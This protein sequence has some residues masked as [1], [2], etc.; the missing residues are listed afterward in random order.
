MITDSIRATLDPASHACAH[1]GALSPQVLSTDS[2]RATL[3]RSC[4]NAQH[5]ALLETST[6]T[7]GD[8][9]HS[10]TFTAPS[11]QL[12]VHTP[13]HTASDGLERAAPITAE[14]LPLPM[15]PLPI[16]PLPIS[17]LP[18]SPQPSPAASSAA[19][20]TQRPAAG[21]SA[22]SSGSAVLSA[23]GSPTARTRAD[24]RNSS[25]LRQ[26]VLRGYRAQSQA[27]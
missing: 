15:S 9:L 24:Q 13:S 22:G 14:G 3:R 12:H 18:I 27:R 4:T 7:A 2:I 11:S 16:F 21:T 20:P 6:Y 23:N 19:S 25:A 10:S 8:V 1:H 17:P 5:N 26:R